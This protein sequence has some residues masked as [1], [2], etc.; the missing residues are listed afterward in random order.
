M[1]IFGASLFFHSLRWFCSESNEFSRG[2]QKMLLCRNFV[3]LWRNFGQFIPEINRICGTIIAEYLLRQIWGIMKQVLGI[4]FNYLCLFYFNY[5]FKALFCWELLNAL[6]IKSKQI[7][8][9]FSFIQTL[10]LNNYNRSSS[11]Q[12]KL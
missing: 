7:L 2:N 5:K 11:R 6:I 3:E 8:S 1:E 4:V 9:T 10:L 12:T